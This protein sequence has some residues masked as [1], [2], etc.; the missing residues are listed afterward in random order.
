MKR[1][2]FILLAI[3]C[4]TSFNATAFGKYVGAE[5]QCNFHKDNVNKIKTLPHLN[6][7]SGIKLNDKVALELGGY[8]SSKMKFLGTE[9]TKAG[10]HA[11]FVGTAPI[12]KD[13]AFKFGAGACQF[14]PTT[15]DVGCA[16]KRHSRLIPRAIGGLEIGLADNLSG[17]VNVIWEGASMLERLHKTFKNDNLHLNF[18]LAYT[19]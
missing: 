13:V 4:L 18:G 17:R 2:K 8:H 14:L 11:M 9:V 12:S 10:I 19:L 3:F 1:L 16:K 6:L 7:F 15:K 5:F